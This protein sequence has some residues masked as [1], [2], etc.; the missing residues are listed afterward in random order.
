MQGFWVLEMMSK[1]EGDVISDSTRKTN[2]INSYTI[3]AK[4]HN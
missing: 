2:A 4:T 1:F 3:F